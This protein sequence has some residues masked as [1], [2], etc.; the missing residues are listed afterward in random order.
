MLPIPEDNKHTITIGYGL[1]VI[2]SRFGYF[3][4]NNECVAYIWNANLNSIKKAINSIL[5]NSKRPNSTCD[6][7]RKLL[8]TLDGGLKW[9][10]S[11]S[12]LLIS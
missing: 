1:Y 7:K 8:Q 12:A 4:N 9:V 2:F 5:Y 11:K 10:L 6:R 3:H